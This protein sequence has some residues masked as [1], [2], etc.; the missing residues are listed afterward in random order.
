VGGNY[1]TF[2]G[3]RDDDEDHAEMHEEF[4]KW[5]KKRGIAPAANAAEVVKAARARHPDF[6][7]WMTKTWEGL[8]AAEGEG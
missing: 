6:G 5:A 3:G 4:V 1:D 8:R 7:Q 2:D